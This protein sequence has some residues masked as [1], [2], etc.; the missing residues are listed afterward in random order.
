MLLERI[1]ESSSGFFTTAEPMEAVKMTPVKMSSRIV[2]PREIA[3]RID[4]I[5]FTSDT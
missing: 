2:I 3:L 5:F 4:I 1:T